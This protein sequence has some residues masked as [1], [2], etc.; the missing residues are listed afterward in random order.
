M[1]LDFDPSHPSA[2]DHLDLLA[3][4]INTIFPVILFGKMRDPWYREIKAMLGD[5]KIIPAPLIVDV[6]QRRDHATFIPLLARLLGTAELPQLLLQGKSL[7]SY[8]QILALRDDG[9]FS[10]TL[11]LSGAVSVRDALKKKK[12]SKE[13]ERIENERILGPAPIEE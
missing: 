7:G 13:K 4:E 1:I 9:T 8:H 6:D 5:Y 10:H 11:E 12:G 3:K 2:R